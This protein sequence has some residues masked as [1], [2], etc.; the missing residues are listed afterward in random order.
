MDKKGK[1]TEIKYTGNLKL[2]KLF[3]KILGRQDRRATAYVPYFI[4][5]LINICRM[6]IKIFENNDNTR[7]LARQ[8]KNGILLAKIFWPTVKNKNVL[9]LY[10]PGK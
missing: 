10:M 6:Q 9:L 5:E 1:V 2:F 7:V 4:L 8:T 3:L